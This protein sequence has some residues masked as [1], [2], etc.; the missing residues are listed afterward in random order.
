MALDLTAGPLAQG[1]LACLC[2]AL[3]ISIAG[4]V[5]QCCLHPGTAV[6]MDLCCD[7]GPGQ[8]QAAV[9]IVSIYPTVAFPAQS[10]TQERCPTS[11]LAVVLEMVVYRCAA[12]MGDDGSPPSCEAM[13]HDALVAADDAAAMRCAVTCCLAQA[14]PDVRFVL[15][16]WQPLGVLGACHGGSMQ[17]TVEISQFCPP[18][19]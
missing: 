14:A 17:V 16:A 6:P 8:G 5:C 3:E 9:R 13:T 19:P 4:P 18:L 2:R 10:F 15:G 11:T 12:T 7:C 1:L